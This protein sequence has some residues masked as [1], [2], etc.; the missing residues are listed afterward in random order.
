MSLL[1]LP[2][3]E[4]ILGGGILFATASFIP[5][6]ITVVQAYSYML[7]Y[8]YDPLWIKTLVALVTILETVF[9]ALV[10][11]VVYH[12]CVTGWGN[13]ILINTIP[14]SAPS[15]VVAM[16]FVVLIV[17]GYYVHRL[18]ILSKHNKILTGIVGFIYIAR[19]ALQWVTIA[20]EFRSHF[21]TDF[22]EK[23]VIQWT[24]ETGCIVSAITDGL[25]AATL[26]FYIRRSRSPL[27]RTES[28]V[29]WIIIYSVNTGAI[30]MIVSICV[31]V[32]FITLKR[33]V[34]FA[35]L[36]LLLGRSYANSFLGTLNARAMLKSNM[37]R[38]YPSVERYIVPRVGNSQSES[39]KFRR[40][41]FES[42]RS[43]S[44]SV[45]SFLPF[46]DIQI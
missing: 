16:S 26:T 12:F 30:S 7:S 20:N 3:P 33:S 25:I 31:A 43:G 1:P 9:S 44:T 36:I 23:Q 27:K 41:N 11:H 5:Y 2:T 8:P 10:L 46:S 37:I 13:F 24:V 32:T 18:W 14:W 15:C 45:R 28:V 4:Y 29:R 38:A 19:I 40:F 39:V 35:G 42:R 6:G 22:E 34:I 21:W 17:Q